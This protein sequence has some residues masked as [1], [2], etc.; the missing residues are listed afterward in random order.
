MCYNKFCIQIWAQWIYQQPS[1]S[2]TK[3]L[4]IN[5]YVVWWKECHRFNLAPQRV[6][7]ASA[8]NVK[9]K[10]EIMWRSVTETLH[11]V[12]LDFSGM[13][14]ES[15]GFNVYLLVHFCM[16]SNKE[17][18]K[19]WIPYCM[20][21]HF[22]LRNW[23]KKESPFNSV[24]STNPSILKFTRLLTESQ[25]RSFFGEGLRTWFINKLNFKSLLGFQLMVLEQNI[26]L[27]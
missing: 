2:N 21:L 14:Y 12:C 8:R 11:W 6:R 20:I 3:A 16:K 1:S 25:K 13:N 18:T 23:L 4:L 26:I 24:I 5:G 19:I 7:S 27:Q 10:R 22:S 9:V 15:L 17:P